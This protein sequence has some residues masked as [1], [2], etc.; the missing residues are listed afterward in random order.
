MI[1]LARVLA[2]HQTSRAAL[3]LVF[4]DGEE[5]IREF[6]YEATALRRPLG[7]PPLRPRAFGGRAGAKQFKLGVLWDMMG[8]RDL[9]ITMP[10]DSPPKLAQGIF[11]ASD[12]LGT[13]GHFGYFRGD[14]LDDHYDLNAVG[15]PTIDLIDF[16]F[17][18][19]HTPADTLDKISAESLRIVGQATLVSPRA[20][21]R[22]N[23]VERCRSLELPLDSLS[24][25]L[26][27]S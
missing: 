13:R 1:E 10:P 18:A 9:T 14:I 7:Q 26:V 6:R 17:P 2:P 20:R 4:F 12:A 22:R 8:K 23:C 11:A 21:S 3:E 27:D 19:W 16:N 24:L 25:R 15:I 5:A